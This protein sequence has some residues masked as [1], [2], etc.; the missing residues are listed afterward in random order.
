M[1]RRIAFNYTQALDRATTL[2]WQHG[3]TETGL[4]ELLKTME[5]GEG[6]F[7]NTLKSKKHLYLSC[8]EHYGETVVRRRLE[9]LA[10]AATAAEGI[11]AFFRVSLDCLDAP[12]TPSRL[13]LVAAM[14]SEQVLAE[15]ELR[16]CVQGEL[17]KVRGIFLA[18]LEQD[19]ER[20]LLPASL[21]PQVT[22]AIITTYLQGF[23]RMALVGYDRSAF[24][25]QIDSFLS[26]MGL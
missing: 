18:R 12:D 23:W 25:R 7:Y 3:Y 11:R 10:Q 20:G 1:A 19:R 5:I 16:E 21:D 24:E 22:A 8:V 4:R 9:A 13:C 6:S 14:V 2:F 15:P 26:A 17:E